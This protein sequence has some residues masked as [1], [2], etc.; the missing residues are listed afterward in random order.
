MCILSFTNFW[1][2]SRWF[3]ILCIIYLWQICSK[4]FKLSPMQKLSYMYGVLELYRFCLHHVHVPCAHNPPIFQLQC[5]C[6]NNWII[7]I[8][9]K[10][11]NNSKCSIDL[12][13]TFKDRNT[14][15]HVY[16][17]NHKELTRVILIPKKHRNN[18]KWIV[19]F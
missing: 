17:I 6:F 3:L 7:L 11:M 18:S 5:M 1:D 9:K 2:F 10:H 13:H 19:D 14:I 8:P 15:P 16:E 12:L 4:L